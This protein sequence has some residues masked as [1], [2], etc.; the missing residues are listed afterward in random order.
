MA[1]CK[2]CGADLQGAK[3]C[4]NCGTAAQD[5][6]A[7]QRESV[8]AAN[9]TLRQASIEECKRML[10]YFGEKTKT[11]E[12][13][14]KVCELVKQGR[15]YA[16]ILL[17]GASII[18]LAIGVW[19]CFVGEVSVVDESKIVL[20]YAVL[21]G[22]MCLLFLVPSSLLMWGAIVL[23]KRSKKKYAE[24][25]LRQDLLAADIVKHWEAYGCGYC[26]VGLPY[27]RVKIL[28]KISENLGLG[29]CKTIDEAVNIMLD[30][31]YKLKMQQQ[32]EAI[33]DAAERAAEAA[34]SAALTNSA[35]LAI[36]LSD[37]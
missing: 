31:E 34:E 30:D 12:E 1:F 28:E 7:Q 3:F 23:N 10:Q 18:W 5:I 9:A 16:F 24:L 35:L 29:R 21:V 4:A 26:P 14:D 25:C 36:Y 13:Y 11:W 19:M 37:Y 6:L 33:R 20:A 8:L 22:F 2:E 17:L 27:T 32:A 15:S